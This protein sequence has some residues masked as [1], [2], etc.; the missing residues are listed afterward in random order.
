VDLK[1][2]V[3]DNLRIVTTLLGI[4]EITLSKNDMGRDLITDWYNLQ[5][6][7]LGYD[8]ERCTVDHVPIAYGE[9]YYSGIPAEF[10]HQLSCEMVHTVFLGRYVYFKPLSLY[11]F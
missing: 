3:N 4:P 11:F 9:P 10:I 6:E 2:S 1:N 5:T 8:L 7:N